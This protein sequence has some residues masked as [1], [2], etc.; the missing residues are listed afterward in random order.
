MIE[1]PADDLGAARGFSGEVLGQGCSGSRGPSPL[2]R[3]PH[4]NPPEA[5]GAVP[6]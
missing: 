2:G 1:R 6:T 4:L 5:L 3:V